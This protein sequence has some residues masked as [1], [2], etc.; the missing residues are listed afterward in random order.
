MQKKST[1]VTT[2][3]NLRSKCLPVCTVSQ[4]R[5]TE[6][7]RKHV[8][9]A[10]LQH[11]TGCTDIN[12]IPLKPLFLCLFLFV[13][14]SPD[15][16]KK[17]GE[18]KSALSS[19]LFPCI[20]E[21]LEHTQEITWLVGSMPSWWL[22]EGGY[23]SEHRAQRIHRSSEPMLH[24]QQHSRDSSCQRKRGRQKDRQEEWTN[25]RKNEKERIDKRRDRV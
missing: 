5:G 6:N 15:K 20:Y 3:L 10:W 16:K 19:L 7:D 22:R 21:Q 1:Q 24:Q 25:E 17:S 4:R 18:E 23:Y 9:V 2:T 14:S 12:V 11:N 13:F 8:H